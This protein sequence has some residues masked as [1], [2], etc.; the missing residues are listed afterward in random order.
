MSQKPKMGKS[1]VQGSRLKRVPRQSVRGLR[2][3]VEYKTPPT[4]TGYG[5]VFWSSG[6]IDSSTAT[7]GT[8]CGSHRTDGEDVAVLA[9]GSQDS[10][11]GV[12]TSRVNSNLCGGCQQ[13][14]VLP[15]T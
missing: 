8:S 14:S 6:G 4:K 9:R 5:F 2:G 15:V 12:G 3:S 1:Q 13:F 7:A 10:T 11:R